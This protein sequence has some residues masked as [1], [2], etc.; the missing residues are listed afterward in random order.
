MKFLKNKVSAKDVMDD[1]LAAW[2]AGGDVGDLLQVSETYC[3][4]Q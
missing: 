2:S 1:S 3:A 4:Q